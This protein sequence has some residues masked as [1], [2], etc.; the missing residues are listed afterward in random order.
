MTERFETDIPGLT[1]RQAGEE[2]TQLIREMLQRLA[3]SEGMESHLSATEELLRDSLFEKGAA[4]AVIA[5]YEG[6]PAGLAIYFQSY[7]GFTGMANIY[8]EDFVIRDEYR[9]RGFGRAVMKHLARLVKERGCGR[10]E[11]AVLNDNTR[12]IAFYES[13]GASAADYLTVYRIRGEA[14]DKLAGE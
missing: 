1:L 8:L 7:S 14:L 6:E 12:G 4:E 5:E 2:D 3:E 11:W 9:S 13:I 10:L